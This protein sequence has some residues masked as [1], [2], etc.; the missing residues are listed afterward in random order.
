M[1]TTIKLPAIDLIDPEDQIITEKRQA[2]QPPPLPSLLARLI[3]QEQDELAQAQ[4]RIKD[5]L[6]EWPDGMVWSQLL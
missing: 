5:L 3:Q 4:E 1:N 6:L 2:V